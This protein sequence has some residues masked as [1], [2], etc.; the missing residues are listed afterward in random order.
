MAIAYIKD[1]TGMRM[2]VDMTHIE[3]VKVIS[4]FTHWYVE[5]YRSDAHKWIRVL[6]TED[7][8]LATQ[9]AASITEKL[10]EINY[11]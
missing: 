2:G 6:S 7:K 5:C 11:E 1:Q 10:E 8:L 4:G 9:A 3:C